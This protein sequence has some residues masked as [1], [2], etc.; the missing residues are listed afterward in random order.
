[1]NNSKLKLKKWFKCTK[2]EYYFICFSLGKPVKIFGTI[3]YYKKVA[4]INAARMFLIKENEL[5]QHMIGVVDS[6]MYLTGRYKL[7]EEVVLKI[8]L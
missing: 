1:M 2:K 7:V 5:I 8:F 3:K 6:W 4:S